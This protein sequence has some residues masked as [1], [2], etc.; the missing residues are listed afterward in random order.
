VLAAEM[1]LAEGAI[2]DDA[3]SRLAASG[4]GATDSLRRHDVGSL[5]V[6]SKKI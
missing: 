3:L 4:G 6:E 5:V 2:T 1:A